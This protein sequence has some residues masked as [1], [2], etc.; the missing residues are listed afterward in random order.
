MCGGIANVA[1]SYIAIELAANR[2]IQLLCGSFDLIILQPG[3]SQLPA[4]A[5]SEVGEKSGKGVQLCCECYISFTKH[6]R[7]EWQWHCVFGC[8]CVCAAYG[9]AKDLSELMTM[10]KLAKARR[11]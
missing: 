6:K 10:T 1:R 3:Q 4:T 2:A 9:H 5:T 8:V 7:C 11:L